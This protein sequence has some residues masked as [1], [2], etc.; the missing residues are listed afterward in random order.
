MGAFP[1]ETNVGLG[2]II[3]YAKLAKTQPT[4]F[5]NAALQWILI[6]NAGIESPDILARYATTAALLAG[7]SDEAGF[8]GYGRLTVSTGNITLTVDNALDTSTL[9]VAT[10][11]T[12]TPA[13]AELEAAIMLHFNPD[14][15]AGTNDAVCIPLFIDACPGTTDAGGSPFTYSIPTTGLSTCAMG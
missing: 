8:T 3:L 9:T 14:T 5:A 1:K 12:W 13:A 4:G 10:N 11:P 7:A 15:T 2:T 6:K